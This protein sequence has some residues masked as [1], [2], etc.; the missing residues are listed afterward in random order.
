MTRADFDFPANSALN[1]SPGSLL[2]YVL[3]D[4][5][6]G[7]VTREEMEA[8]FKKADG[9]D[10]GF[11]S[12]NDLQENFTTRPKTSGLPDPGPPSKETLIRGLFRREIGSLEPGPS[13]DQ[14]APDFTLKT[15]DGKGEIT[16]SKL[17]GPKPVVLVF[18]NFTCGPFR[19][20]AG[21]VEKLYQLYKD[22]AEFVMVYVREAHPT[23]GWRMD[24]NDAVG[25][26]T[27][28]PRTYEE[29]VALART[30]GK[31]LSLGFPML[32]DG[33]DDPV[34]NAYSGMPSRLYLIDRDGKV[35]YKSG[36][37]PY[38]FL[39]AELEHSLALLLQPSAE[40]SGHAEA[41]GP[42]PPVQLARPVEG[43]GPVKLLSSEEAWRRLPRVVEGGHP[44]LPNWARATA[45]ALPQTTAAMLE[46]DRLHRTESPL[47]PALRG[48]MRWV[49][50]DTNRCAYG[51]AT[52]EAD[53]LRA[54]IDRAEIDALKAGP[55]LW[56]EAERTALE[57]ASRMSRDASEVTDGQVAALI[58]AHGE[59]KVVAMVLLLAAANFQDRLVM[60]L[61]TPLETDGPMAPV[62]VR[63]AKDG[64]PPL[65]PNR[66][67]PEDWRGPPVPDRVD[68]PEWAVLDFDDLRKGL[69][70]QKNNAGRIRV[71]SPEEAVAHLPAD[72]PK[73]KSPIRIK[74][75]LVV[76][77][78]QPRLAAAWSSVMRAF[79]SDA[80]LDDVFGESLFWVVTKSIHCFY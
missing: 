62:A 24:S 46:L 49:A 78:Y 55:R 53:L 42:T 35:A 5:G 41:P 48:K 51:R 30:C 37:G 56:P 71:P 60:G 36:R 57:F 4:D 34:G 67:K 19:S 38:G 63:F 59:E 25:I 73:P 58:R 28:Q 52:A 68:D 31:R 15:V 47:G 40:P 12:L 9:G 29:R 76:F 69:D 1:A 65:V 80:H 11:L 20:Q 64:P 45:H 2:M 16:L 61:G 17:V 70:S 72:Y 10:L 21:N 43:P 79:D 77:G 8:F 33:I 26:T 7:K 14:K 39:P 32:V 44:P 74:W 22:R 3:D 50:A 27:A 18:G 54:G 75:S 23:D 66:G 13:L 6:N